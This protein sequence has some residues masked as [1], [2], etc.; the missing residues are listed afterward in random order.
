VMHECHTLERAAEWV[1]EMAR[2]L[3]YYYVYI[4]SDENDAMFYV[5]KGTRD[6]FRQHTKRWGS[7]WVNFAGFCI[8]EQSAI[9]LEREFILKGRQSDWPLKNIL[10]CEPFT[11]KQRQLALQRSNTPENKERKRQ[12]ALMQ[13]AARRPEM[14]A[15]VKQICCTLKFKARM[16]DIV[17]DLPSGEM[18]RRAAVRWRRKP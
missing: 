9:E 5:G 17:S 10:P 3:H 18:A 7:Y 13:W 1:Q 6:R 4:L 12:K 15:A 2:Q 11:P 14:I 16:K 8:D